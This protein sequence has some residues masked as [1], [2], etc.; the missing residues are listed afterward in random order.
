MSVGLMGKTNLETY[1]IEELQ[2]AVVE[3]FHSFIKVFHEQ[4]ETKKVD[5]YLSVPLYVCKFCRR[6]Y[7][8]RVF[9]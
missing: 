8:L 1:R 7:H 6:F 5:V 3:L 9:Q 2:E 4:D